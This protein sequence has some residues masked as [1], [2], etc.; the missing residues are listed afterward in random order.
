MVYYSHA[1]ED[2]GSSHH[3]GNAEAVH[4]DGGTDHRG[5]D[6]LQVAVHAY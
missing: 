1:G 3:L 5:N 2:T 4:A 6:R